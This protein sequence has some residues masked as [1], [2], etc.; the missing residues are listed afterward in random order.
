MKLYSKATLFKTTSALALGLVLA[1][2]AMVAPIPGWH[3]AAWAE[4]D[5]DGDG[6]H[7]SSTKSGAIF[8]F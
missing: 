4:D 7:P 1:T 6:G 8:A 5:G 3:G 2:G